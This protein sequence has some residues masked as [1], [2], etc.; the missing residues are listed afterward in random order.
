MNKDLR[1]FLSQ[2][3]KMGDREIV[4]V[5]REVDPRF[6]LN[7]VVAKLEQE[8]KYPAVY[9]G[10]V[11]G[12]RI[13]VVTNLCSTYEKLALALDTKLDTL[14]EEYAA[15]ERRPVAT[16][17]V[18]NAPVKE[19]ILTGEKA[20]LGILPIP[21]HN[22]LDGGPYISS[23]IGIT[24]D[25]ET[26]RQN[27]G[28]YRHMV[29]GSQTMGVY[30]V[31]AH[32]IFYL[33]RRYSE[34][35]EEMDIA[36]ALG[37]HPALMLGAISRHPGA[38]GELEVAGA[39][40]GEPLEVVP[41]E[42]VDLLVPAS[43]EIIVEGKI[44]PGELHEE[45][46]FGEWPRYYTS[47]GPQPYMRV[48]AI[49]MRRDPIYLDVCAAH[50]DHLVVGGLP[51]MGSLLMRVREVVPT[52]KAVNMP[53]SGGARAHCYISMKKQTEG[54]PKQAAFA[55]LTVENDIK[56]VIVVDEDIN[57]FNEAEVLWA[58]ATRFEADRDLIVMPNCQGIELIP[59][60]YGHNRNEHGNM[61]TKLILDATK[62]CPP[63]P[64]PER[65]DVPQDLLRSL[66]LSEYV[67]PY[68]S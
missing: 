38:G 54:E 57:A 18:S 17:T 58:V 61:N 25:P 4:R 49:T 19:T 40:L 14:V 2:L 66:N 27:A 48:T 21:T 36:I 42:T 50:S 55:A 44:I 20:D 52:V 39:L 30:M 37:H 47:F 46:P 56:M 29:Y 12:S 23:G 24:K 63:V 53:M 6:E 8:G 41:A 60:A 26:G 9:F 34:R 3:A 67:V 68:G 45:G 65:A 16:R 28:V 5:R 32:H 62:P 22:A 43:A 31:R 10:K 1:S 7:T 59:T 11:K 64:F 13:P 51:R 33:W 35:Q 15:R